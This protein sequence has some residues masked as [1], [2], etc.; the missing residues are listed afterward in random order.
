ML[1]SACPTPPPTPPSPPRPERAQA[2]IELIGSIPLLLLAALACL[3]ALL[4]ALSLLFAQG[5]V[6]R[7]ARGQSRAQV[8]SSVPAGWRQRTE[9]RVSPSEARVRIRPPAVLP[10]AARLHVDAR[11]EVLQ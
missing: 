7:A 4:V 5:A 2:S 11:S 9:V 3:Q 10:G 6:D 1:H 8:V